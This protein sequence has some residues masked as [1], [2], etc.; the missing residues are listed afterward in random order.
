MSLSRFILGVAMFT[1]ALSVRPASA[2]KAVTLLEHEGP[3][4]GVA[5]SPG[6]KLLAAVGER[7]DRSGEV[8]LW[9]MATGKRVARFFGQKLPVSRVAFTSGGKVL[10]ASSKDHLILWEVPSGKLLSKHPGVHFLGKSR[11]ATW[12][13]APDTGRL[14]ESSIPFLD[15]DRKKATRTWR[16]PA[17][18]TFWPTPSADGEQLALLVVDPQWKAVVLN[19]ATLTERISFPLPELGIPHALAISP[20][21]NILAIGSGD[22]ICLWDLQSGKLR[23]VLARAPVGAGEADA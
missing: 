21:N 12:K 9:E 3:V 23:D 22:G 14:A 13:I 20:D 1:V 11:V 17:E 18:H 5:F 10:A 19:L 15:L 16:S 8:I 7:A 4:H 2:Q 6:G